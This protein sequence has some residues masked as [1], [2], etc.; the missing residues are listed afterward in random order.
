[1]DPFR[2]STS[3]IAWAPSDGGSPAGSGSPSGGTAAGGDPNSGAASPGDG[4]GSAPAAAGFLDQVPADIRGEAYFRD[5]RDVGSL[6][7]KAFHQAK[8]IGVPPDQLI[9]LAGPDDAE[10]WKGIYDK[11]GR[12]ESPDKYALT[13]PTEPPAGFTVNAEKKAA[14]A[15]FAHQNGLSQK[16]ADAA[17]QYF[18]G[19]RIGRFT[20]AMAEIKSGI[21]QVDTTLKGEWGQA[22]DQKTGQMNLAIAHFAA[23]HKLGDALQQAID[24]TPGE[25]GVAVRKVFAELGRQM[26]EDGVIGKGSGGP[27]DIPSPVEAKQQIAALQGDAAFTKAFTDGNAPGHKD[28]V[29]KW[30]KLHEFAYP[31]AAQAAA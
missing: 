23:Q 16:Q 22:Y 5:I 14:F 26:Q 29:E 9:R 4:G 13:D 2:F 3:R 27:G 1:M 6:A 24:A 15:G 31:P 7:T 25:N 12:P 11:L 8:L 20:E 28:A 10:G 19:E 17:Y 18:N 21:D 30:N